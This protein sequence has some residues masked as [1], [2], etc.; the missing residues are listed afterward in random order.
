M[1][2]YARTEYEQLSPGMRVHNHEGSEV[3]VVGDTVGNYVELRS[4]G[5]SSYWIRRDEFG[6]SQHESVLLGLSDEE[7]SARALTE[8]PE[9]AHESAN[10]GV[11]ERDAGEQ[12]NAMLAQ[13]AEQRAEMREE[14]RITEEAE[15]T[16]GVPVEEELEERLND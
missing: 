2:E 11:L 10:I 9:D 8:L 12:R 6:E 13:L 3:G 14:G 5:G 15:D 16:I 1:N 7:F 4:V